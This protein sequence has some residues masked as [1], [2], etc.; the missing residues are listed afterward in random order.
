MYILT[1]NEHAEM[2]HDLQMASDIL[3]DPS[4]V[5]KHTLEEALAKAKAAVDRQL[6]VLN[7]L[8]QQKD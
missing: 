8:E 2:V 5:P 1:D 7:G 6:E 4:N 3:R